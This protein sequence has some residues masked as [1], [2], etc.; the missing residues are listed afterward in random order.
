MALFGSLFEKRTC[1]VCGSETSLLGS[2]RLEDGNLCEECVGRLS[3]FFVDRRRST[4][5]QIREQLAYRKANEAEVASFDVTRAMGGS[6]KVLL[7]GNRGKCVVASSERWRDDNPD[8][9]SLSQVTGCDIEVCELRDEASR[10]D[11]DGSRA[12]HNPPRHGIAY[13]V[14]VTI[15][16]SSPY[17][18]QI[19]IRLNDEGIE[20][21]DSVEF[22]EA[23][24]QAEEIHDAL[25]QASQAAYGR[26]AASG[27]PGTSETHARCGASA[28]SDASCRHRVPRDSVPARGRGG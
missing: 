28:A 1:S 17:F 25:T 2:L 6:T 4:V 18:D 22:L 7:D 19:R 13:N 15:R 20:R 8:V 10:P 5:E 26:T 21:Q 12:S 16:V 23:Y 24:R 27:T 9:V 14:E 11:E 3:P